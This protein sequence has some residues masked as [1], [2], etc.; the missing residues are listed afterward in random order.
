MPTLLPKSLHVVCLTEDEYLIFR[1]FVTAYGKK[2]PSYAV[3]IYDEWD[4]A[5]DLCQAIETLFGD[6][7]E[8]AWIRGN[9]EGTQ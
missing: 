6:E 7:R 3:E 4:E 5:D 8:Q 2:P 9:V 1:D